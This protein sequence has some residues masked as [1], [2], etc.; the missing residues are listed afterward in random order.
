MEDKNI[1][2]DEFVKDIGKIF[3]Y[4]FRGM[5]KKNIVIINKITKQQAKQGLNKKIQ[6][7]VTDICNVCNGT[8]KDENLKECENCS[9][10]G[11]IQNLK[12]INFEIPPKVKNNDYIVFKKQGNKLRKDEE[13]GDII[14]K[15][16]IYGD[17]SKRKGKMLYIE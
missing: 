6:T 4:F 13:R 10:D 1:E 16:R 15:I 5:L 12:N 8:G 9:G 7:S 3:S 11:F 14:I 2:K 17:R